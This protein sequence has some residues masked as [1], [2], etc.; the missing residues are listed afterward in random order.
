MKLK[1]NEI[2][3]LSAGAGFLILWIAEYQRTTFADSYWLMML[4]LG[5]MLGFQYIKNKRLEREKAISPTIKQM[6]EDRSKKKK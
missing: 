1:L 3:L 6:A 5:C 4:S 2:L